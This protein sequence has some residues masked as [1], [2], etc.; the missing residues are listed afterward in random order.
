[1]ANVHWLND[2]SGDFN[3]GTNWSG[4][5][6]PGVSDDVTLGVLAGT[7][8]TVTES[9]RN[10]EQVHSLTVAANATLVIGYYD[11][12][13][14]LYGGA[15]SGTIQVTG[16]HS[17]FLIGGTFTNRGAISLDHGELLAQ[18]GSVTTLNGGGQIVMNG[19]FG[20]SIGV[21]AGTLDNVDNTI[22][23]GGFIGSATAGTALT[24]GTA[25]VINANGAGGVGLYVD[26]FPIT[27]NGLMESTT[28]TG[29]GLDI[30]R[31]ANV[32][33]S[34]GGTI[35]AADGALVVLESV[36]ITGGTLSSVGTGIFDV[37]SQNT[38]LDGSGVVLA[39]QATLDLTANYSNGQYSLTLKGAIANSGTINVA[40]GG[41]TG[42][43]TDVVIDA[44]GVTLSGAGSINLITGEAAIVG[45]SGGGSILTNVA[46]T[47]T[48]QGSIGGNGL[49]LINQAKGVIDANAAGALTIDTGSTTT[50]NAGLIEAT[51]AGG[52][53]IASAITNTGTLA[54]AGGALAITGS[55]T[56]LSGTTLNGGVFEADANSTLSFNATTHIVTDNA[57]LILNGANSVIQGS[58]P[59][60]STLTTIGKA[61]ALEILGDRNWTSSV[62]LSNA[63]TLDLGGGTF[64]APGLSN[65][66]KV[67]GFGV[68]ATALTNSGTL[69]VAANQRL[70]L[71]GGS[72]TNLS[73]GTLT[74][75]TYTVGAR[76][77][78]Q[79]ANNVSIVTLN[80][81]IDLAGSGATVQSLN[82]TTSK[83]V[84]LASSL[85]TVGTVGVLEILGGANYTTANAI[86]NSGKIQLGGGTFTS[87]TLTDVAGSSLTG[88]GTVASVFA[89][90]G[91]VTA[92]SGG[93]AFTGAGDAF[94]GAL[95][96]TKIV[97]AGGAD[98]LKAGSSLTAATVA[99][100]GG[101]AVTLGSS[102]AFSG[103][104]SQGAG[105]VNLGGFT[106][107]LS[108]AGS[109]IASAING[110]GTLA[111]TG[112][113]QALNSG[114]ALG[115][116]A[117]SISGGSGVSVNE[118]LTF[119]GAFTDGGSTMAI[120]AGDTLALTGAATFNTGAVVNGAGTLALTKATLA[121][122]TVGGTATL[123]DVGTVDQ[124]GAI[125]IGDA[126]GNAAKLTIGKG[127]T[128]KIDGDVGIARG[129]SHS[130]S[131]VDSGTL[132]RSS[133]VGKSVIGVKVTDSGLIEVDTGTLDFSQALKGNGA[134]KIDAGAT[135]EVG[136][137]AASGLT[138]TF[139]GV[140][141][142]LDL[143]NASKFA[144]TIA[145][146]TT[147]QTI[148]LLKTV[149]TR[150]TV[151]GSDQLVI[152]NGATT[153]A[154]LQLTGTYTGDT[155]NV[156]S[157]GHGG[158][159]ITLSTG[160]AYAPPPSPALAPTAAHQFIA[161]M[162]GIGASSTSVMSPIS[163]ACELPPILTAP[164]TE[165]A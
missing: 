154:T 58:A 126:A 71:V 110:S 24:N 123:K 83:E 63:G 21:T 56:N 121:G 158:T 141:A 39:N 68:L 112:G 11:N 42:G 88:F 4:G 100:S 33:Q 16:G 53:T 106:L 52:L 14:A 62:S 22:A 89:D 82:T 117:W 93:L 5:T 101:A 2:V 144:A 66:G 130:S 78:L 102:Q 104:W 70:S 129:T 81:T 111:F 96:G 45:A 23:G 30:R 143:G 38:V 165:M 157:D 159:N 35:L 128:Y 28:A 131:L 47:I 20:S 147:G 29:N 77:V 150:A 40:T 31:G 44:A 119:A 135:L 118:T 84:S 142:I 75:G 60:E 57:T 97:F 74:G 162:A 43:A 15:N 136:G 137:S 92:S 1:M 103:T 115:A 155:F 161:A 108:G 86:A 127:D 105:T 59:L 151:N 9:P 17:D 125:T 6:V 76:G 13:Q 49:G 164:R 8:Y 87:G 138:A 109:T 50:A 149:A 99:I 98:A 32:D 64:T 160:A 94:A 148:D 37:G 54:A 133:G 7:P 61:G 55:L 145:G 73:A 67:S 19:G 25:G 85:K 36:Q 48:G 34:G 12:F 80:A 153:V 41:H 65:T 69:A 107:T 113:T 3:T 26:T 51:G 132:I 10:F 156:A 46:N 124:S 27:N 95:G 120:A 79:L 152:K 18:S 146:F 72:L 114:A 134:M 122:L 116:S 139:N 163:R 140:G 91:T 90:S